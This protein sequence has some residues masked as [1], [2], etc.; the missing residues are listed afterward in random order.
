MNIALG[1]HANHNAAAHRTL[2]IGHRSESVRLL[3]VL[4]IT[5]PSRHADDL[6]TFEHLD[7]IT[8]RIGAAANDPV[9]KVVFESLQAQRPVGTPTLRLQAARDGR[10]MTDH[11]RLVLVVGRLDHQLQRLVRVQ[12]PLVSEF[13]Q[14]LHVVAADDVAIAELLLLRVAHL[15]GVGH[16]AGRWDVR[17]R[18]EHPGHR[19]SDAGNENHRQGQH[20]HRR[21]HARTTQVPHVQN[22]T[23][24]EPL[25]PL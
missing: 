15:D 24:I 11:H 16:V 9:M 3:H 17:E 6:G 21:H 13:D 1:H 22:A 2:D 20:A 10:R 12:R 18:V 7:S 8:T 19:R 5:Q 23:W 4:R 14:E 25:D